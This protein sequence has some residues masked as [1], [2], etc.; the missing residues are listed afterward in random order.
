MAS[1]VGNRPAQYR[2]CAQQAREQA[3]TANDEPTRKALLH[4]ADLWE[5]MADYEAKNPRHD[6]GHSHS[7]GGKA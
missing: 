2:A 5:R 4:D 6:F 7:S 3:A 1:T